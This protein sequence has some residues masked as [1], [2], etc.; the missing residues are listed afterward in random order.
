MIIEIKNLLLF[1]D[2]NEEL[3]IIF[4]ESCYLLLESTQGKTSLFNVITC[5]TSQFSGEILHDGHALYRKKDSQESL[6]ANHLKGNMGV[7]FSKHAL[8]SNLSVCENLELAMAHNLKSPDTELKL[9]TI[10]SH[11]KNAGLEHVSQKRPCELSTSQLKLIS[12][13]RAVIYEP[14]M[15]FWDEPFL[16]DC[17]IAKNYLIEQVKTISNRGNILVAF[18]SNE[19]VA[20][21]LRLPVQ[22]ISQER[23]SA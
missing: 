13:I 15:L 14:S 20:S 23:I 4:K 22:L 7:I 18:G 11:L 21:E 19:R 12:F 2:S 8:I 5:Q 10:K 17:E 16:P 9:N 3:N 1:P 6:P